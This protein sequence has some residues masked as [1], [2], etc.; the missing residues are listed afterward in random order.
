MQGFP[1]SGRTAWLWTRWLIALAA[2]GFW[3]WLFVVQMTMPPMEHSVPFED[4]Y[5]NWRDAFIVSAVFLAFVLGFAW[6]RGAAQWRNAGLYSA[7]LISLFVEMF[8]VPLTIYIVA[9]FL[10]LEALDFGMNESHLWAYL[11]DWCG[12]VPLAQGVY[13][14]MTVSMAL[15]AAGLALVAVG[16]VQVY[17][18]R[19]ELMTAGI[20]RY[21]RHP[22]YLG[23][24]LVVVALNIQWPTIPTL[25]MAPALIVMYV[26]QAHRE[27]RELAA[28]F[29]DAFAGYR[30]RVPAFM[31]RFRVPAPQ[32]A[33]RE[34]SV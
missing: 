26:R 19:H 25:L 12:L 24:M 29:G 17:G 13:L 33:G 2:I 30:A 27:D 22:Q 10:R 6:P 20:Y 16:W 14:V 9:P 4:W 28:R 5:G 32:A 8:G 15:V 1:V 23:L 11:L 3:V 31:P 34:P 18:A 21:V 7:F